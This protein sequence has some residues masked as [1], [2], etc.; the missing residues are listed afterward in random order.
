M[1]LKEKK[2][3]RIVWQVLRRRRREKEERKEGREGRKEG[4]GGKA[5]AMASLHA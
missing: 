3:A 1:R 5:V 4:E 2:R